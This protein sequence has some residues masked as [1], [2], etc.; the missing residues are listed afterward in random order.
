[1]TD[2]GQFLDRDTPMDARMA[3]MRSA[4]LAQS[5][6]DHAHDD[7]V[8]HGSHGHGHS[9]SHATIGGVSIELVC[10]C[11]ATVCLVSGW[12]LSVFAP[13]PSYWPLAFYIAT[14]GL[15]GWF[16]FSEAWQRIR[17]GKFEIDSLMLLAAAGQH[18]WTNGPRRTA[19][20]FV[21][22]RPCAGE[23]CHGASQAGH[24][25][26]GRAHANHSAGA[27]RWKLDGGTSRAACALAN[28]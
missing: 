22:Y 21:Q 14:Y 3:S 27:A 6:C 23:L 24:R 20:V 12:L 18:I 4:Q 25:S 9:H 8:H 13:A 19:A 16:M 7:H 5:P 28:W 26:L 15:T 17:V 10:A 1:M 2:R 11:L